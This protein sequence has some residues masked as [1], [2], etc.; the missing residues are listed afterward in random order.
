MKKLLFSLLLVVL[1]GSAIAQDSGL[2]YNPARS[3]EG[4]SLHRSGDRVVG[5]IFTYGGV[6]SET[7]ASIP[8][9]VSPQ[10][11]LEEPLNGQRWFLISGDTL[12]DDTYA[13][14]I[15]Y[16][17]GGINYPVK[18]HPNDIG[19]AVPVGEYVLSRYE[20]GWELLVAPL[21]GGPLLEDDPL[22]TV[23]FL[24]GELLFRS[25]D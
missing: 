16:S 20:D 8:P 5:F 23:H 10:V 1:A 11:P 17:T 22:F 6:E 21:E 3:G 24:F 2:Y 9:W 13:E 18:L 15:L 14:G 19:A 4:L 7:P 12:I 25:G